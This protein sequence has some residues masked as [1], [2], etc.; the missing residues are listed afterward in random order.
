MDDLS[1]MHVPESE[2]RRY[3]TLVQ[4]FKEAADKYPDIE[5][6]IHRQ[7]NGDRTSIT[8]GHFYERSLNVGKYLVGIGVKPG[9]NIIIIG[10]NSINWTVAAVGILSAGAVTVNATVGTQA[11]DDLC[12]IITSADCKGIV[13]GDTKNSDFI[14]SIVGN[15]ISDGLIKFAIG[16]SKTN[17]IN[18]KTIDHIME[19]VDFENNVLPHVSPEDP[20]VIFSTSGS[21]RKPKLVLHTHFNVVGFN[22]DVI[23]MSKDYEDHVVMF[24]DRPFAWLGGSPLWGSRNVAFSRVFIDATPTGDS[25]C[26]EEV[27]KIMEE[28]KCNH[29]VLLPAFLMDTLCV[30]MTPY[31]LNHIFTGGQIVDPKFAGL[32]G[33]WTD[34]IIIVYAS[35]EVNAYWIL[36]SYQLRLFD[37]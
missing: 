7:G 27:W 33:S 10:P 15:F 5:Y 8:Y 23:V 37:G 22:I 3:S 25:S 12:D 2:P 20:A 4:R 9:E 14:E 18:A 31:K 17:K 21:T 34:N 24:N 16:L 19:E 28:E 32:I 36:P 30:S 35:S 1:Y 6:L 13:F 29:A 26:C 11:G